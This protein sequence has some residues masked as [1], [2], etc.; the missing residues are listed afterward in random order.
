MYTSGDVHRKRLCLFHGMKTKSYSV[1]FRVVVLA[2]LFL[3][4]VAG[5]FRV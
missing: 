1:C 4:S 5:T 3:P 2:W